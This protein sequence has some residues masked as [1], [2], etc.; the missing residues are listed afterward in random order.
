MMVSMATAVL[1]TSRSPMINSRLTAPDRGHG[2]NRLQAQ[3]VPARLH[4][5]ARNNPGGYFFDGIGLVRLSTGPLPSIGL[6]QCIH[7]P[8]FQFWPEPIGTSKNAARCICKLWPSFNGRDNRQALR[9][10][11]S[12]APDSARYRIVPPSNSIISP[13]MTSARP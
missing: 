7:H 12:P 8:A 9:H 11:P 10:P 5:L 13:Y 1:P 3:S 4:G 6:T 2:V